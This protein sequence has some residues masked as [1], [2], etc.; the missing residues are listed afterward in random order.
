MSGVAGEG[1]PL[2]ATRA[3]WV[4]PVAGPPIRD[5]GLVSRGGRIA[6]VGPWQAVEGRLAERERAGEPVRRHDAG[7]R[8]ILPALVNAH[9]HLELSWLRGRLEG[10]DTMPDW[11]RA[12]VRTRRLEAADEGAASEAGIAE[13]VACGTGAVGDIA[14]TSASAGPLARSPLQAVVFRELIGF[15]PADPVALVER[16][17][18]EARA[19]SAPNVR[20]TLSAH[21][22]YS[23][24]PSLFRAIGERVARDAAPLRA[25]HVAESPEEVRFLEDGSGP[26]R[27]LLEQVGTWAPAWIAPRC[28][29]VQYLERLGWLAGDVILVHGVQA[30]PADL[31]LVAAAGAT[32]VT[33][34]RSSE[35]LRVGSPP[36]DR[37][38]TAG[39]NLAVGTDSLASSDDLNLFAELAA[40]RRLAPEAPAARLL[41]SAT[42]AGARALRLDQDLGTLE[43]GKRARAIAVA[44]RAE[45]EDVEEQ[46]L[47]GVDPGDIEWVAA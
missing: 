2:V 6:D 13:L 20:V 9:T 1:A 11:V 34:P 39:V 37:F 32:L 16:A 36:I 42:A 40:M 8:A 19:Q 35:R 44:I 30:S 3:A 26:W 21:A 7:E 43:V 22:P 27:D 33:C 25:V 29:P 10:F 15:A 18:A 45:G 17:A 38:L 4:L 5:G 12:L 28:S 47:R 23:V 24:A 14:N 31:D 41:A 46:L